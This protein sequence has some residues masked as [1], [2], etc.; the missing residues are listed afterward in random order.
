M[1]KVRQ[2]LIIDDDKASRRIME[3]AARELF[4]KAAIITCSSAFRALSHIKA[5]CLPTLENQNIFCP[6]LILLDISMP[7]IDGYGFLAE[8]H[9][10]EGLR[11]NYTSILF[12]S[13]HSYA[14]EKDKVQYFPVLGYLEKPITAENLA[15]ALKNILPIRN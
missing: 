12:V 6:E 13:N 9:R 2:V 4:E 15:Y 8:L 7:I 1:K 3:E 14:E 11:H 5:Y 10:M